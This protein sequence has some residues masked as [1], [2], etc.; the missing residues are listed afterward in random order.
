MRKTLA[1]ASNT[2]LK[3]FRNKIVYGLIFIGI[4]YI[5]GITL[6]KFF[7]VESQFQLIIDFSLSGVSLIGL[8]LCISMGVNLIRK[9]IETKSIYLIFAKPVDRL[10]YIAG[11]FLGISFIIGIYMLLITAELTV[12]LLMID[13]SV[14][15]ITVGALALVYF[16]LLVVTAIVLL[17][18]V[19]VS[20]PLNVMFTLLIYFV[21]E[22]SMNYIHTILMNTYSPLIAHVTRFAK[23]ILPNFEYSNINY[24]MNCTTKSS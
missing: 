14:I 5:Y 15:L 21:G 17:M 18:S 9:E 16:K 8:V 12:V 10:E 4:I 7:K 6:L 11:K 24:A 23:F 2:A 13:R 19:L 3:I 20:V 1:I 22:L